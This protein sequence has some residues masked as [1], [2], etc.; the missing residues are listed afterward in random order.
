MRKGPPGTQTMD[1]LFD[2]S[3]AMLA[4]APPLRMRG[5][6]LFC[7]ATSLGS[8]VWPRH[9]IRRRSARDELLSF[10]AF[11]ELPHNAAR[12][13]HH[14]PAHGPLVDRCSVFWSLHEGGHAG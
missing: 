8:R 1:P 11:L 2:S 14:P 12:M 4:F 5:P 9:K 10:F 7:Q 6:L 3:L 13:L